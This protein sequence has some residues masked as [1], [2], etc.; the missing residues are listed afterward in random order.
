[1]TSWYNSN[2]GRQQKWSNVL[3]QGISLMIK[4]EYSL[5]QLPYCLLRTS[6]VFKSVVYYVMLLCPQPWRL[7]RHK[8]PSASRPAAAR[9][10]ESSRSSIQYSCFSALTG[11]WANA[12]KSFSALGRG[13]ENSYWQFPLKV[14]R[15]CNLSRPFHTILKLQLGPD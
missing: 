10:Y 9:L 11:K 4:S 14:E 12:S 6:A 8:V 2:L 3:K 13:I 1:M 5:Y 15:Y 7:Y